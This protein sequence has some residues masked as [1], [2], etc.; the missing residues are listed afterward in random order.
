MTRFTHPLLLTYSDGVDWI[1]GYAPRAAIGLL[2]VLAL[3]GV[4]CG[5]NG[6]SH[7]APPTVAVVT[8]FPAELEPFLAQIAIED[9][10]PIN[11]RTFRLGTL[12]G[13]PVVIGMTGIGLVNAA[14]TAS[15]LLDTVAVDGLIM[16]GV[17]GSPLRIGDV[18]VPA[19]WELADDPPYAADTAWL[20]RA[21][22]LERAGELRFAQCTEIPARPSDEVCVAHR[23][24]LA[25]G[26]TGRS[27]DPFGNMAFRCSDGAG[28]VFGCELAAQSRRVATGSSRTRDQLLAV[29]QETAA[30]AREAAARGIPF[31]AFRAVSDGEGDP[32]DLPGF[33][34]QFFTYYRLAARNAATAT[35]AFLER[36]AR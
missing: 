23:P 20:A 34:A 17:A 14:A 5:S 21:R 35:I 7:A 2:T 11:G 3:A 12:A 33:P 10:V 9:T 16:S 1:P 26:G 18:V 4:G 27:A 8:A 28:D 19:A 6:E 13:V 36:L 30:V 32:L 29:D 31:I 24:V 22:A 15:A 25:V